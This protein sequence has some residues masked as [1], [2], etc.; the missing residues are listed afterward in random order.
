MHRIKMKGLFCWWLFLSFQQWSRLSKLWTVL[1]DNT[2]RGAALCV[3]WF[4]WL[5]ALL[6]MILLDGNQ[7]VSLWFVLLFAS[8]FA[9]KSLLVQPSFIIRNKNQNVCLG[10]LLFFY[11]VFATPAAL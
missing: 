6:P 7:L 11:C 4:L 8:R 1:A 10:A 2:W 5:P 3:P 9:S